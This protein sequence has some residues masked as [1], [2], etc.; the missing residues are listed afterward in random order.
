MTHP[1]YRK[2]GYASIAV[3]AGVQTLRDR[4]DCQF[5]LLVCEPH[6]QP[7]YEA[8]GWQT[9]AGELYCEQSTGR[10]RFEA[11]SPLVFDIKR[12]VRQGAIDLCGL[13]W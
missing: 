11:M 5:G 12:K 1:D 3:N 13:P 10:V 9:F 7:F 4:E 2:R 8:R 6:N